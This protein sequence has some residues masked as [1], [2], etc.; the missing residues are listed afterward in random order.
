LPVVVVAAG[1]TAC[2]TGHLNTVAVM[3]AVRVLADIEPEAR[4]SVKAPRT[5]LLSAAVALGLLLVA[6]QP[7]TVAIH[8]RSVLLLLAVAVVDRHNHFR[9][10]R[11]AQQVGLAEETPTHNIYSNTTYIHKVL[12]LLV[13]EL[14]D[15]V[16]PVNLQTMVVAAV[17][18][19]AALERPVEQMA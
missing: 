6:K 10:L 1:A 9:L 13:A 2:I 19:V 18:A 15:K 16:T 14:L 3:L 5:Q 11:T 12:V 17:A 8:L 7:E 4:Q